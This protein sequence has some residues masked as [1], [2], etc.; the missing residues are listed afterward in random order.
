MD[1]ESVGWGSTKVVFSFRRKRKSYSP[2]HRYSSVEFDNTTVIILEK[3]CLIDSR[4]IF[5]FL[6]ESGTISLLFI[7]CIPLTNL[8][9][10]TNYR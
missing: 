3:E 1:I 9:I 4:S 6:E 2:A 8:R 7:P 5:L 10:P